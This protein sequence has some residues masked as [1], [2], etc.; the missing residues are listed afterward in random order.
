M[1]IKPLVRYNSCY[2]KQTHYKFNIPGIHLRFNV[3]GLD[4]NVKYL[5]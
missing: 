4:K 3:N 1:V 5:L 2:L